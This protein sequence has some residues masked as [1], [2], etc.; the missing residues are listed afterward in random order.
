MTED[1][2]ALTFGTKLLV[3]NMNAKKEPITLIDYDKMLDELGI[4]Q[5]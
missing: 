1:M 4:N 5:A 2:D 3:R